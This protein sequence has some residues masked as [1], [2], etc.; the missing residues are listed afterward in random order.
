M[1]ATLFAICL[2]PLSASAESLLE[3]AAMMS[4]YASAYATFGI[5]SMSHDWEKMVAGTDA[6]LTGMTGRWVNAGAIAAGPQ[7]PVHIMDMED[8]CAR[9]VFLAER[10]GPLD[11]RITRVAGNDRTLTVDYS[12][13][14]ARSFQVSAD[15]DQVQDFLGIPAEDRPFRTIYTST[16][17]RGI[18]EVFHPSPRIM[19]IQPQ[20]ALA[21]I[22]MRCP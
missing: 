6:M 11:F 10:R 5:G 8:A 14:F 16:T 1:R 17:Y 18:V 3:S 13:I 7:F 20:G 2:M 4:E 12:Y 19:V 15:M 9:N 21:D 22:Y